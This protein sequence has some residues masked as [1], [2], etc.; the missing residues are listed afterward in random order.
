[1]RK[2]IVTC[3]II[4]AGVALLAVSGIRLYEYFNKYKKNVP[5]KCVVY[6]RPEL[7]YEALTDTLATKLKDMRSFRQVADN[8]GLAAS[9]K[10]GRYVLEKDVIN[11][12]IVHALKYGYQTPLMVPIAGTIRTKERL[13][14]K[15]GAKLM[16]DSAAF[17]AAFKDTNLLA[18]CG[19]DS[20]SLLSAFLPD[21]YE[22]FWTTA[23]DKVLRRM[24][25]EHD[26]FWSEER[27]LKAEKIGLSPLEVSILASI[28]VCE[29]RYEPE[30][31]K[32]A[33]VYLN[34]LQKGWKLCADPTVVY[35][36]GDFSIG[37]VLRRHLRVDS[38]FNTYKYAGLPPAPIAIP[39]KAAI[40][41]VLNVEETEYLYFCA[42]PK[43]DGTHKF[44]T[45]GR[46]H[47]R[48]ARAYQ[49]VID[50][51]QRAKRNL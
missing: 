8:E 38:P 44:A 3:S 36:V 23:P 48:N 33:S 13:A 26:A 47:M 42:N 7:S 15:L 29:S 34:R 49:R 25:K 24:K 12:N 4:V 28:V 10:P 51:L 2:K 40:D 43:R 27:L 50:S 46:E 19:L 18:E 20:N 1:M 41:G 39:T 11:I 6:V 21:S 17:M 16:A 14:Q 37:R 22:M 31:P 45:T 30:Y 32:I 5:E 35:A 9:I